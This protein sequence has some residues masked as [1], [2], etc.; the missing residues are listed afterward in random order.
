MSFQA[1]LENIEAKTGKSPE[2]LQALA[3]EKG[4]VENGKLKSDVKATQ[5]IEWLKADFDLGHGHAM[6]IY[7]YFKGKRS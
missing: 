5:I 7:A 1:Y 2:D 6:S 3:T 4:F